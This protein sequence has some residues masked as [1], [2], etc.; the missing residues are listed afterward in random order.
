[1]LKLAG[2]VCQGLSLNPL[3]GRLTG[4]PPDPALTV[5]V[6]VDLDG[7]VVVDLDGNG[8]VDVGD[9]LVQSRHR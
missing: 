1:M 4:H 8:D 2:R 9:E 3:A 5:G 7:V 6:D